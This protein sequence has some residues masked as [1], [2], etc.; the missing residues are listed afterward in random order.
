MLLSLAAIKAPQIAACS[1][2]PKDIKIWNGVFNPSRLTALARSITFAFFMIPSLSLP[3][4]APTQSEP[5]PPNVPKQR[6]DETVELPIPIS[7]NNKISVFKFT[8]AAPLLIASRHSC[9]V[10]AGP[11]VI[12]EVACPSDKRTIFKSA[13]LCVAS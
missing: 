9:S 13:L 6:A 3:V 4:P 7:P 5:T 10:M 12:S 2:P 11:T 8:A 1:R